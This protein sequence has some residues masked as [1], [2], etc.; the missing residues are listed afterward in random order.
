MEG[1]GDVVRAVGPILYNNG[2]CRVARRKNQ[3]CN[4]LNFGSRALRRALRFLDG[5]K[6]AHLISIKASASPPL[7][8]HHDH[9][10]LAFSKSP[11]SSL[12]ASRLSLTASTTATTSTAAM[13][14][15]SSDDIVVST[16]VVVH[17]GALVLMDVTH[18]ARGH[19]RRQPRLIRPH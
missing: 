2:S 19:R 16:L 14:F 17:H 18:E 8:L 3:G 12:K 10:H 15:G 13:A 7:D 9:R 5:S 6:H 1:L 4:I 11:S